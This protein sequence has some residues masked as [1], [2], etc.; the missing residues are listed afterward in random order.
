MIQAENSLLRAQEEVH[1]NPHDLH[2]INV[3]CNLANIQKKGK[4]DKDLVLRAKINWL[5]MGDI[6]DRP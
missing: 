1:S 5:T 3:E 4:E 2:L 6:K